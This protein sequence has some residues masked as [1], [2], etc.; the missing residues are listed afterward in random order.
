MHMN[1][2]LF[3]R[4]VYIVA[5]PLK[6]KSIYRET[7]KKLILEEKIGV[8]NEKREQFKSDLL[9]GRSFFYL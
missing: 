2:V 4:L 3:I 7:C 9:I 1:K 6:T 8:D 5:F